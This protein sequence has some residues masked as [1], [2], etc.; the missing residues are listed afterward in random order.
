MLTNEQKI[1]M[2]EELEKFALSEVDDSDPYILSKRN[3][4][5]AREKL[6]KAKEEASRM[7]DRTLGVTAQTAW[8]ADQIRTAGYAYKDTENLA[9]TESYKWNRYRE[10]INVI[11]LLTKEK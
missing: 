6:R 8:I 10:K 1:K 11:K 2:T 9:Q 5:M 4:I 3:L 7:V